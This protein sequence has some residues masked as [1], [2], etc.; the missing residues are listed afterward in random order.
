MSSV[1]IPKHSIDFDS[2]YMS[3]HNPTFSDLTY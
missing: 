2:L 3:L 1:I